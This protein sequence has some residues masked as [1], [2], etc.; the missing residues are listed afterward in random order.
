MPRASR[1]RACG[2]SR[3]LLTGHLLSLQC[4]RLLTHTFNREYTH[5]HVCISASESKVGGEGL[6]AGLW[7]PR[8]ILP[9]S[10]EGNKDFLRN[11]LSWPK[12]ALRV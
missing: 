4:L 1:G 2:R 3:H 8:E 7:S 9:L 12:G 5:S 10:G 6:P 11:I